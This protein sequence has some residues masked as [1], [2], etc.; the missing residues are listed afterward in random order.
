MKTEITAHHEIITA[1]GLASC[2][3]RQIKGFNE[4]KETGEQGQ[5]T[6]RQYYAFTAEGL[7][8]QIFYCLLVLACYITKIAPFFPFFFKKRKRIHT[9]ILPRFFF[10]IAR[11]PTDCNNP[12]SSWKMCAPKSYTTD[13]I[14]SPRICGYL[15]RRRRRGEKKKPIVKPCSKTVLES[16][17]IPASPAESEGLLSTTKKK[18]NTGR[19][20]AGWSMVTLK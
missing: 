2:L 6:V 18:K 17:S 11:L 3:H 16:S 7:S 12:T 19:L 9:K 10:S 5:C 14:D 1:L 8:G 15:T 4:Q 20:G 13:T